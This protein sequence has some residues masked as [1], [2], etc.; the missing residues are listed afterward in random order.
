M[1]ISRFQP[2]LILTEGISSRITTYI[3]WYFSPKNHQLT[4]DL[5]EIFDIL[6]FRLQQICVYKGKLSENNDETDC[7]L[8][9]YVK[10]KNIKKENDLIFQYGDMR[11]HLNGCIASYKFLLPR[12]FWL[13]GVFCPIMAITFWSATTGFSSAWSFTTTTTTTLSLPVDMEKCSRFLVFV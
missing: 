9:L 10:V 12:K 11:F 5:I 6:D 13:L 8:G 7:A 2:I 3:F 4:E 1:S